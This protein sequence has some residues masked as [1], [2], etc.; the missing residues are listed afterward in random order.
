MYSSLLQFGT[1]LSIRKGIRWLIECGVLYILEHYMILHAPDFLLYIH[2]LIALLIT[3]EVLFS[4]SRLNKI[5]SCLIRFKESVGIKMSYIIIA[6]FGAALA[7]GYWWGIQKAFTNQEITLEK[8]PVSQVVEDVAF[9]TFNPNAGIPEILDSHNF[10]GTITDNGMLDF[11]FNFKE[12]LENENYMVNSAG[13]ATFR[14][15]L[16]SITRNSFSIK[17]EE[18]CPDLVK[19]KFVF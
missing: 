8:S 16:Y 10:A 9:I 18:P 1:V 13:T 19:L 7:S 17:F 11:T 3:W 15:K 5:N 2:L 6:F 4:L 14:F 12:P